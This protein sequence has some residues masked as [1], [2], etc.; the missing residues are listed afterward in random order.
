LNRDYGDWAY[1]EYA[2]GGG[3]RSLGL[4]EPGAM[5]PPFETGIFGERVIPP[6]PSATRMKELYGF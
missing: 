1:N 4:D 6:D 2:Q 3:V 5:P